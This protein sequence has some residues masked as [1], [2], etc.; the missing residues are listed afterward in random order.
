LSKIHS[1]DVGTKFG[2]Y[3]KDRL[4]RNKFFLWIYDKRSSKKFKKN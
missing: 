2:W 3:G 4:G 1:I